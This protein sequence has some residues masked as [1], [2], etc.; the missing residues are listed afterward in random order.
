MFE[1]Y[2]KMCVITPPPS[3]KTQ[4]KTEDIYLYTTVKPV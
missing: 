2:V 3:K 4:Q 1:K